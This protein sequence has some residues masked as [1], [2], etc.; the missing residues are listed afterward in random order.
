MRL[1]WH[2]Y[3]SYRV[4][5]LQC[6]RKIPTAELARPPLNAGIAEVWEGAGEGAL[7]RPLQW[8]KCAAK[9]QAMIVCLQALQDTRS[10]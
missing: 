6:Q 7:D 5:N 2:G 1:S 4:P 8:P 9:R 3:N 10:R